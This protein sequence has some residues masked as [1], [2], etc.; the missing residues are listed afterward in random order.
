MN[1]AP[2][3]AEASAW[4]SQP[5][6]SAAVARRSVNDPDQLVCVCRHLFTSPMPLG[7]AAAFVN[8][9]STRL[10]LNECGVVLEGFHDLVYVLVIVVRVKGHPQAVPA[11]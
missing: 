9:L 11:R 1:R 3:G 4:G 7:G 10:T 5:P 8:V 6:L 2:P